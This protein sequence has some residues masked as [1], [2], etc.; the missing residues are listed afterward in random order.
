[1]CVG[2]VA[3]LAVILRW[4]PGSE[5]CSFPLSTFSVQRPSDWDAQWQRKQSQRVG[6]AGA[7]KTSFLH[8]LHVSTEASSRLRSQP[9]LAKTQGNSPFGVLF[10]TLKHT[11][12]SLKVSL[13][14]KSQDKT[15]R[16]RCSG[17]TVPRTFSLPAT[18]TT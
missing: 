4:L 11:T 5:K 7:S 6:S 15:N 1:M 17:W 14:P 3:S 13:T 8:R 10:P 2:G 12:K 9:S 18:L 16:S